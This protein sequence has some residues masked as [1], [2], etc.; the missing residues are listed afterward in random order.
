MMYCN[1]I[2]KM[3]DE[4]SMEALRFQ[5]NTAH[6]LGLKTTILISYDDLFREES[7]L[8]CKEQN[9][10]YGDEIGC[11]MSTLQGV[12]YKKLLNTRELQLHL[13]SFEN[14]K[15]VVKAIFEKFRAVFGYYPV[16]I[17]TYYCSAPI[18]KWIKENYPCVK[19]AIINCF[20]EGIHM[21]DGN[22]HGWNLFCEG[23]PWGAYYPS[24]KNSMCPADSKEDAIGIVGLPHLNRDMIMAHIG[25][26]DCF[27][28]HSANVQ[29]G[30]VNKGKKCEYLYDFFYEWQKQCNYNNLVYY[31][32]LVGSRWLCEGHNFEET[33][34]DSRDLYRQTLQIYK[35]NVDAGKLVVCTMSEYADIHIEKCPYTTVDINHWHDLLFGSKRELFWYSSSN[36]RMTVDPNLGGAIVDLRPYVGRLR[37]VPGLDSKNMWQ[38]SYPYALHN[39]HRG[40]YHTCIVG[41]NDLYEHRTTA[42]VKKLDNGEILLTMNPV[43]IDIEDDEVSVVSSFLFKKDGRVR[44]GR[45]ILSSTNPEKEY[46]LQ[47]KFIGSVG[48]GVLPEDFRG[49]QMSV[50]KGN[51]HLVISTNYED[52]IISMEDAESVSAFL[53]QLNTTITLF[54]ETNETLCTAEEG[55]MF[56]PYYTLVCEHKAVKMGEEAVTWLEIK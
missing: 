10:Q 53:P 46:S 11:N 12:E 21:Y 36:F 32:T 2:H 5:Q 14:Q 17:A 44:I 37:V 54:P 3:S 26:D 45:K 8:Y 43:E 38:G 34:E 55:Y 35:D 42:D 20:E 23:S 9:L 47:E 27:S 18:L 30:M 40:S 6:E 7:I 28:S 39:W 24:V 15:T 19:A 48:T 56:Y 49:T 33:E 16:S 50:K 52:R 22:R 25:R 41:G 13:L 1:I 51:E 29:R 31:N 4:D